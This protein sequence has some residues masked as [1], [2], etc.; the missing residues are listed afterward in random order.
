MRFALYTT[1]ISAHQLPLAR[2]IVK[3]VG[4]ENFRYIY[5]GVL[6][7]GGQEVE[8]KEPWIEKSGGALADDWLVGCDF[9]LCGVRDIDLI[10]L[11]AKKGLK[12]AYMSERWFK[13]VEIKVEKRGGISP[14]RRESRSERYAGCGQWCFHLPGRLRMLVPGYWRMAKRVV[15]WLKSDP[16]AHYL[17]I[18]PWA[19]K[20]MLWLG[21][22]EEKIVDWGY[23]VATGMRTEPPPQGPSANTPYPF[24]RSSAPHP[25]RSIIRVLWVGRMLG[26][27]RVDTIVRAVGEVERRGG[28]EVEKI[29]GISPD[30][31]KSRSERYAWCGQRIS[32]TLVGDG[33]EKE[34]LLRLTEKL[35]VRCKKERSN[36][37][38]TS[39][40][41]LHLLPPQP[42]EKIREIMREHD[43][44]VLA[45]NAQEGWGA[46][47]NEALEEGMMVLGT[48]E[49]GA[50][51]AL[52][53]PEHLFHAGDWKTLAKML[54]NITINGGRCCFDEVFADYSPAGAVEKLM[55]IWKIC[56]RGK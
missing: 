3:R 50:S 14:D 40:S 49:A 44:Y 6:Q 42:I 23:V 55:T 31:R 29:G 48:Y 25:L 32:L 8:C 18:G 27:K 51:A 10:E 4:A 7:G 9:L 16:N 1:S 35:G 46:T 45:S 13:P 36:P 30:R 21:V 15:R 34:R 12:T 2:E 41:F 26:W 11:R 17:A 37:L 33:P 56:K 22:P 20:D 53:P 52:L 24:A 54:Y 43:V 47:V 39:T 38:S 5:T 19:K 28:D